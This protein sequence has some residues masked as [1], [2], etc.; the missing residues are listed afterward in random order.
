MKMKLAWLALSG[1]LLSVSACKN[2]SYTLGGYNFP[3]QTESKPPR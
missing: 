2:V 1:V 3:Q